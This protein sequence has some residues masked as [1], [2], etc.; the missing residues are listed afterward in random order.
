MNIKL[1]LGAL[2]TVSS[3][4]IITI[5]YLGERNPNK[6]S[7]INENFLA[8][9]IALTT[10]GIVAGPMLLIEAFLVNLDML[11]TRDVIVALGILA[12]GAI[13]LFMMLIK[14]RVASYEAL[15]N[16]PEAKN[17]GKQESGRTEA[18]SI[19]RTLGSPGTV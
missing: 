15:L 18:E 10:G 2:L 7:W 14:K 12:A 5:C 4:I 17:S 1:I 6:S 9:I 13:L 3:I 19:D 16:T 8:N 11:S